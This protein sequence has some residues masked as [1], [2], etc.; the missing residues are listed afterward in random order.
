MLWET[1]DCW[2]L[3]YLPPKLI[4]QMRLIDFTI[5][6]GGIDAHHEIS[7]LLA[8][9]ESVDWD[10]VPLCNSSRAYNRRRPSY[11]PG[12]SH[13][14]AGDFVWINPWTGAF[15]SAAEA[16]L[17]RQ[18]RNRVPVPVEYAEHGEDPRESDVCSRPSLPSSPSHHTKTFT[19][20]VRPSVPSS[21]IPN[22]STDAGLSPNQ[23]TKSGH[24]QTC[25][26]PPQDP[27]GSH[28]GSRRMQGEFPTKGNSTPSSNLASAAN[29]PAPAMPTN[30]NPTTNKQGDATAAVYVRLLRAHGVEANALAG[31]SLDDLRTLGQL[32]ASIPQHKIP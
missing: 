26:D 3:W 1:Y 30:S 9:V 18:Y 11:S 8:K 2:R 19:P 24:A 13:S 23:Q 5:P 32:V 4:E 12:R 27:P 17:S 28:T 22:P 29:I 20:T 15:C 16:R 6:L 31:A 10:S 21:P 25:P 7:S 14:A